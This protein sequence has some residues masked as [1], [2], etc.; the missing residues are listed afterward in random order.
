MRQVYKKTKVRVA[1]YMVCC[2]SRWIRIARKR[3]YTSE[4]K[5]LKRKAEQALREVVVEVKFR[6]KEVWKDGEKMEKE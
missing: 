5:S 4:Y 2:T 1:T 3:E 6:E